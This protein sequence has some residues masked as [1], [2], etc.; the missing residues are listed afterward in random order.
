LRELITI[1]NMLTMHTINH[2]AGFVRK[3]TSS[4]I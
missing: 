3:K 1:C 4:R 2:S